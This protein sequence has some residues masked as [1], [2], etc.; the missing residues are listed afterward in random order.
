[1]TSSTHMLSIP[2]RSNPYRNA[3]LPSFICAVVTGSMSTSQFAGIL[4]PRNT[5]PLGPQGGK[6]SSQS[7]CLIKQAGL[8]STLKIYLSWNLEKKNP[9]SWATC[10]K[11]YFFTLKII[12]LY[13]AILPNCGFQKTLNNI[14]RDC[15]DADSPCNLS[16]WRNKIKT[17]SKDCLLLMRQW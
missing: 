15:K 5:E 3:P 12:W 6:P 13:I 4:I 2:F 16:W 11:S 8:V 17:A 7:K 14:I 1:M 10:S 9:N